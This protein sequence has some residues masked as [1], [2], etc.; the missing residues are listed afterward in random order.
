[1]QGHHNGVLLG[2][3]WFGVHGH[4]VG[5]Y[6]YWIPLMDDL[7]INYHKYMTFAGIDESTHN[8]ISVQF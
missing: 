3:F 8:I 1:M 5:V 6:G 2:N 4:G 7:T